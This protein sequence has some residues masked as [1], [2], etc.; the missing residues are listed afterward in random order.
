MTSQPG[1]G[2]AT[3]LIAVEDPSTGSVFAEIAATSPSEL[4]GIVTAAS[5]AQPHW[6]RS[7]SDSRR[8]AL[9]ACGASIAACREELATLLTREQGKPLRSAYAEVDLAAGWFDHTA[10]LSLEPE[11]VADGG[12]R[13]TVEHVPHGVIAAIAPSNFPLILAVTKLAPALLAGNTVV[14]K[15]SPLTPLAT[16]RMAELLSE[17]LPRGVC[18]AVTGGSRLGAA[19]CEHPAVR[20]IS[21]TGSV[22]TGTAIARSAAARFAR[23]VLELGGND[24]AIVLP[25]ADT[26]T[27]AERLYASAMTNSGQFCA[28]VKRVYVP[29]ADRSEFVEAFAAQAKATVIGEGTDPATD[30]GPVVSEPQ[31]TR[32]HGFVTEAAHAGAE[33]ITGGVVLDRPGHF[34]PPTI[35]TSLPTGTRLENDEQFGP[36]LPVI[37]YSSVDEAVD[38]A[39]ATKFGLGGSVWGDREAAH[40]VAAGLDCGTVWVNTHG[41]LRPDVPFGGIRQSGMGVEYGYWG[42]VE[43][44]HPRVLHLRG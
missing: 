2:A 25:G 44:T 31:L 27:T 21:F 24:A 42:L 15:P 7:P 40:L 12:T 13:I 33:I 36:V 19:L 41:D 8:A 3:D 22:E 34:Y 35:V 9:R 5:A 6:A 30:L 38:R 1:R 14:L 26:A 10:A 39:N 4:G 37:A 29:A 17:V 18:T 11:T 28:A 32:L 16:T 43:Y 23:V 20:L